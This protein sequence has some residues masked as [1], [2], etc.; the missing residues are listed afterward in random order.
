MKI[1]VTVETKCP[2]CGHVIDRATSAF[3]DHT[4]REGDISICIRCAQVNIFNA[5][6]SIRP[7]TLTDLM[8]YDSETHDEIARAQDAIRRT[9]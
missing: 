9:M 6:C 7:A 2:N 3:G 5:D 4:P 8:Q 1:T